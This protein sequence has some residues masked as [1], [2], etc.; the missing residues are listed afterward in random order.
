M[1][2]Y[3]AGTGRTARKQSENGQKQCFLH[4]YGCFDKNES[5]SST[6]M[7]LFECRYN[8]NNRN[9]QKRSSISVS[10][11]Q[12]SSKNECLS[13]KTSFRVR[14]E[15][16]NG[17]PAGFAG[18]LTLTRTR[19]RHMTRALTRGGSKT[20]ATHY[21]PYCGAPCD[22]CPSGKPGTSSDKPLRWELAVSSKARI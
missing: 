2:G 15:S 14:F 4:D 10:N 16:R 5:G 22:A 20:R 21:L 3:G 11:T 8:V 17:F 7:V 18:H 9:L 1:D 12:K 19:T 13:I 6:S